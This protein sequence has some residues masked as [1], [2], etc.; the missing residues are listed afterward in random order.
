MFG[1]FDFCRGRALFRR[2]TALEVKH[3]SS[4]VNNILKG[5]PGVIVRAIA[6]PLNK[7]SKAVLFGPFRVKYRLNC[8]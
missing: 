4:G 3:R 8:L 2:E 7:I 6:L 5:F 1:V